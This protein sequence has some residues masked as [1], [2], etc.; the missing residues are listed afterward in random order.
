M[1]FRSYY[2]GFTCVAWSPDGKFL[3]TGGE[4]D[5]VCVWSLLER[6]ILARGQGHKSWVTE[7]RYPFYLFL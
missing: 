5:L 6:C 2:G 4:D 7:V 3:A 1:A